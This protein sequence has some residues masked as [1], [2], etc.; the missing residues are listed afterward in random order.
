M[1]IESLIKINDP[2]ICRTNTTGTVHVNKLPFITFLCIIKMST[3]T[4]QS[5][6]SANCPTRVSNYIT[7]KLLGMEELLQDGRI[8]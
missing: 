1:I 3:K 6:Q 2:R 4:A 7:A 8:L 5:V